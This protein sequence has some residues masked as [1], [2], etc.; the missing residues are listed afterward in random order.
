VQSITKMLLVATSLC[1]LPAMA[2][3]FHL[4][5]STAMVGIGPGPDELMGTTDDVNLM[6]A[7]GASLNTFGA[8]SSFVVD[9][10]ITYPQSLGFNTGFFELG[11]PNQQIV[12][13]T[14]PLTA[15]SYTTEVSYFDSNGQPA[16][17]GLGNKLTNLPGQFS[18]SPPGEIT[19]VPI[20]IT[21]ISAE[22]LVLGSRYSMTDDVFGGRYQFSPGSEV[23]FRRTDDWELI[24]KT[25]ANPIPKYLSFFSSLEASIPSDWTVMGFQEYFF[26]FDDFPEFRGHGVNAIYSTDQ[27]AVPAAVPLP[28]SAALMLPGLFALARASRRKKT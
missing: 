22:L 2:A 13:G 11:A 21:T 17:D 1:S 16:E 9:S 19:I 4:A 26:V 7:H 25:V 5:T 20:P 24:I 12:M 27:L 14:N 23:L 15:V 3:T 18:L 6:T 8:L 10:G 28:A